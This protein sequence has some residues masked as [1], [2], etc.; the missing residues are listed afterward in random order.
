M[1]GVKLVAQLK[2]IYIS[3]GN[4]EEELEAIVQQESYDVVAIMEMKW[5]E[6]CKWSAAIGG[7]KHFR[8]DK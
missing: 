5:D 7:Y 1:L 4:K 3:M 8:R 2:C 6:A